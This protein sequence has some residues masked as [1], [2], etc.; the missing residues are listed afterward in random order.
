MVLVYIVLRV[1][2]IHV[3]SYPL[4]LRHLGFSAV[5]FV[6]SGGVTVLSD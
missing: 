3:A 2:D 1:R 5:R 6:G 4:F